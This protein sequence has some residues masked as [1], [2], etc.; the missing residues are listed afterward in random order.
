[1]R[2]GPFGDHTGFY[3]LADDYPA[4]D[5][6]AV[7][8]RR[9]AIYPATVVGPPP[10]ED[11]WLGKATERL[12]LPM[13]QMIFPEIVDMAMPVEGVFHNL[14]LLSIKKEHPGQAKKVIHGLWGSGQ[15]A[16]TKTLVVF[17]EDV[18]VQDVSQAAWRAFANVDVKRDLV[19][20]DGPVDVLDHAASHFAF[21]GK[22]GVDATRKW[23]RG[24]RA[25]V[26]GGVRPPAGGRRPD[27]RALRAARPGR[28]AAAPP[29]HRAAARR[30]VDAAA[31]RDAPVTVPLPGE[32]RR[33]S[34]VRAMF[35]RIAPRY[36]L[37]N[38]VMTLKV[39][40]AWRRRLLADLAPRDGEA[41]L[42]LCAGHD[43]RRR[44]RAPARARAA[45][46][47]RR[48]L[49]S[50][51]SARGVE[52]T[53]L[54]ASQADAMALPFH[55]ARFDLATVTF[56]MR[57]L[58]LVRDRARRARAR[59]PPRRPPRRPRVLP[60]GVDGLAPRPRR[61]QPA[62][63]AGARARSSRRTRRRTA[64]SSRRWSGS[65]RAPSSRRRRGAPASATCAARRS[66]P[67]CAGSSRRCGMT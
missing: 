49:A 14:C 54:P 55:A 53:G 27:G 38:R 4:L 25:R 41:M 58:E 35:D 15:M 23:Q 59:A 30:L 52:K 31:R 21:G 18:D 57:N 22:I 40:Q 67:A 61:V 45:G 32:A 9:D 17:D 62:R 29:A 34:A 19:I 1:M 42:D 12:F 63:A 26:A 56:G 5:V 48:L 16:Q 7:T 43:G 50:R 10:V 20:A 2:E 44:P 51:C 6:V 33:G 28:A 65:P 60:A 37:L 39:D 36:D 8:H 3:S 13:L 24:G 46:R 11:Q 66:S 64:T 47:R